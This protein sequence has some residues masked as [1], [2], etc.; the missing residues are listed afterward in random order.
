MMINLNMYS[1]YIQYLVK[2]TRQHIYNDIIF[3]ISSMKLLSIDKL[4]TGEL[5][6]GL[7]IK[8]R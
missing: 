3:T 1:F 5:S 7:N 6:K 8:V 2:S 4:I